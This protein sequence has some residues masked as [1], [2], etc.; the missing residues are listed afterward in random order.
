MTQDNICSEFKR[1]NKYISG[2]SVMGIENKID[3]NLLRC[4]G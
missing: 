1:I 3:K 2:G 4:F